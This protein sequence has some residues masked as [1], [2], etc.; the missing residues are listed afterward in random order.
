[1]ETDETV[2]PKILVH[3][4]NFFIL[5]FHNL[6]PKNQLCDFIIKLYFK[7][8]YVQLIKTKNY[9]QIQYKMI[10]FKSSLDSYH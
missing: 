7:N 3:N 1:M 2:T 9:K 6:S 10:K 4:K 8:L 5:F